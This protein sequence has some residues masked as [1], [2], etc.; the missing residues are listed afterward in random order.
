[1]ARIVAIGEA[2]LELAGGPPAWRLGVAG[3]VF[4]TAVHLARAGHAMRFLTAVGSDAFSDRMVD[5][6]AQ[7]GID[8]ALVLRN[9]VA[10]PGLYAVTLDAHGE[11][12]F[13]YWRDTSAAR[14]MLDLPGSAGALDAAADC[15][16]LYFSLITLAILPPSRH[17]VLFGLAEAVRAR[18]G[19][20]AF[21]SN[22]RPAL[23][24]D[25][26][27]ARRACEAGIAVSTIG[28]PTLDDECALIGET[29]PAA[30]AERW[31]L[32]GC[33]DVVVK[34]GADGCR[35]P[36]GELVRP[37]TVLAPVDTSGAGDAFNGGFL[38]ALFAG[39]SA[40]DAAKAGH[41]LAGRTIMH[42]GAIP[43]R[44]T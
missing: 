5:G 40:R 25:R 20:V 2:M 4:N 7:E 24:P 9:P 27:A 12:S 3:D 32:L 29:S 11:R 31:Q 15:D 17:P 35:L 13:T 26:E 14:T 42:P 18:G 23:W 41:A 30:T 19:A 37:P 22:Y 38:G 16:L 44:E 39:S 1:M 10:R 21:D 33:L 36:S 6:F 34:T 8:T 43:P 28:L